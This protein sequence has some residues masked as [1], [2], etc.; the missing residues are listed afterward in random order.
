MAKGY[1]RQKGSRD[2]DSDGNRFNQYSRDDDNVD[3]TARDQQATSGYGYGREYD[4]DQRN[5]RPGDYDSQYDRGRDDRYGSQNTGY[6]RQ[7]NW[8]GG[9]NEGGYDQSG[10]WGSGDEAQNG[11]SGP[12]RSYERSGGGNPQTRY[13]RNEDYPYSGM[14]R[15]QSYGRGYG[16]YDRGDRSDDD[17]Q[18]G[19]YR[20]DVDQ[21]QRRAGRHDHDYLN[22]RDEQVRKLDDD[23]DAWR[24]ENQAKFNSDFETWRTKRM[25]SQGK[26]KDRDRSRSQPMKTAA[27][28]NESRNAAKH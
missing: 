2:R 25:S 24:K 20:R 14:G 27:P 28:A 18:G 8:G 11:R 26:D 10:T 15:G 22:W 1:S 3:R 4:W 17:R 7:R 19:D 6:G 21:Q 13:G 5:R 9:Y 23:Y 16:D 12:D